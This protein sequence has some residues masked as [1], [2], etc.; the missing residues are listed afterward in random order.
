M[1]IFHPLGVIVDFV[2]KR[3]KKL[4]TQKFKFCALQTHNA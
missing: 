3:Q 2:L 4:I 1:H